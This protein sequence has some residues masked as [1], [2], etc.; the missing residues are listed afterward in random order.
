MEFVETPES[1]NLEKFGYNPQQQ[2]LQIEFKS[3]GIYVYKE[4]PEIVFKEMKKVEEKIK[5]AKT[6]DK[7]PSIG[8]FY[9]ANI[10][11][12]YQQERIL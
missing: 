5:T 10:K 7:K 9:H 11:G 8:K 2:H 3:G 6:S 1:T 12:Q 4:V